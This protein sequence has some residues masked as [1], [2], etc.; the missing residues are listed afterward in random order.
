M[1]MLERGIKS[2]LSLVVTIVILGGIGFA[3]YLVY[4]DS[5][6][7]AARKYLAERYGIEEKELK[8]KKYIKYV[9][10]DITDCE[11]EWFKKCTDNEDLEF[12]YVFEYKDETITVSEDK[13]GVLSDDA[14]LK[15]VENDDEEKDEKDNVDDTGE[16]K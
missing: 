3:V 8:P 4:L 9:Y 10:E 13:K 15:P 16:T 11:T 5:N 12:A 2:I 7:S 6:T 14:K 1:R